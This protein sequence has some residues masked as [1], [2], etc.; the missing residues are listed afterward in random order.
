MNLDGSKPIAQVVMVKTA[1]GSLV[2]GHPMLPYE[3]KVNVIKVFPGMG[4]EP[5]WKGNQGGV[6]TLAES[7]GGY[8]VWPKYLMEEVLGENQG[9]VDEQDKKMPWKNL[10]IKSIS[11]I[12]TEMLGM[13]NEPNKH[14]LVKRHRFSIFRYHTYSP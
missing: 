11:S 3:V 1:P 6:D 9:A 7:E 13:R 12:H 5:I 8:L 10:L 4:N 2:H 14:R